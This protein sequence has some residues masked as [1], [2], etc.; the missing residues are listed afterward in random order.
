MK[1][2][3]IAGILIGIFLVVA[4]IAGNYYHTKK[5]DAAKRSQIALEFC[6]SAITSEGIKHVTNARDNGET[7]YAYTSRVMKEIRSSNA[8]GSVYLEPKIALEAEVDT[9]FT[10]DKN[11]PEKNRSVAIS[12]CTVRLTEAYDKLNWKSSTFHR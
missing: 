11:P 7:A 5:N 8:R 10:M 9:V 12:L 3:T 2:A 1:K 4:A 6:K